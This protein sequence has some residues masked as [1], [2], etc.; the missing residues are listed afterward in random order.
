MSKLIFP[1][2]GGVL[3]DDRTYVVSVV[4]YKTTLGTY[5][6]KIVKYPATNQPYGYHYL[7]PENEVTGGNSG[8]SYDAED[9]LERAVHSITELERRARLARRSPSQKE[10]HKLKARIDFF[11]KHNG[12]DLRAARDL[13]RAEKFAAESGW[14]VDWQYDPE[15]Y[16]MGDAEETPP[17]EVMVA[18]LRDSDNNVLASLGGIGDPDANYRRVVDAELALEA[19][20]AMSKRS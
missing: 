9:A 4:Q 17:S 11:Y 16:Q 13:A 8:N 14:E 3:V 18:A 1:K 12:P 10:I 5:V 2:H 20:W 7:S 6:V 19:M 15:P